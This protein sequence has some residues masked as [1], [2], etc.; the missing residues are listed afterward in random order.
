MGL[1]GKIK[2]A[3]KKV[4]KAIKKGAKKVWKGLKKAIGA[5]LNLGAFIV[6]L[7]FS[8]PVIGRLLG[9]LVDVILHY[10]E[11]AI[12]LAVDWVLEQFGIEATKHLQACVVILRDDDGN[13]VVAPSDLDAVINE[14]ATIFEREANVDF[15]VTDIRT[16]GNSAPEQ[17]LSVGCNAEGWWDDLWVAGS[18]FETT[19]NSLCFDSA[20]TR[21]VGLGSPVVAFVVRDVEGEG[22]CSYGHFTDYVTIDATAVHGNPDI[23]AHEVAHA[24]SLFHTSDPANL[25]TP[26]GPGDELTGWQARSLRA[27]PHVT[28][29]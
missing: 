12:G 24:C 7:V 6:G 2:K 18:Y 8:I 11:W 15:D 27:S 21:L 28:Y 5:V 17:A 13:G 1:W 22:G 10:V 20:F 29:F 23:L 26:G 14:A 19:A 3:A 16:T 4:G 9:Q 25:M